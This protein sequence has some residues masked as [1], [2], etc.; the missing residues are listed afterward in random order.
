MR[1][2]NCTDC[3]DTSWYHLDAYI[4]IHILLQTI[5]SKNT[6]IPVPTFLSRV[7]VK[8]VIWYTQSTYV[9]ICLCACAIRIGLAQLG[10]LLEIKLRTVL[11]LTDYRLRRLIFVSAVCAHLHP[12][13]VQMR[14]QDV[15]IKCTCNYECIRVTE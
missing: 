6:F 7:V 13:F 9:Q 10:C 11:T 1:Y 12:H 15:S 8:L 2:Q 4:Y 3:I 14:T 5:W